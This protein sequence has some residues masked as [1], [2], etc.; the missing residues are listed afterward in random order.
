M[1]DLRVDWSVALAALLEASGVD[2][3]QV[4][5]VGVA[6]RWAAKVD[7]AGPVPEL[8][9]ELGPCWL[10]TAAHSPY[11]YGRLNVAN[12][13]LVYSH[14]LALALAGVVVPPPGELEVDHLCQRKPC[15]RPSHLEVV[16]HAENVRRHYRAQDTCLRGH[17]RTEENVRRDAQGRI[18]NCLPCRREKR[19]A[20]EWT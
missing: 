6:L 4:D 2:A 5:L 11:G 15:V 14:R 9:P 16:T 13:V 18:R 3:R 12:N 19:A 7:F 20:G 10:W 8:R 1:T 17:P